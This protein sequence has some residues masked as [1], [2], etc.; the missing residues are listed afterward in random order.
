MVLALVLTTEGSGHRSKHQTVST[1]LPCEVYDPS[2]P[3]ESD[4]CFFFTGEEDPSF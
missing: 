1:S 2:V 4:L 3:L